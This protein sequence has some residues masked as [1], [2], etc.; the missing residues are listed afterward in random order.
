MVT[1]NPIASI[2]EQ[3]P[4]MILDGGMGTELERRGADLSDPL[5]SARMLIDSPHLI[6]QIHYDYFQAGADVAVTASYQSTL[7]GFVRR[8]IETSKAEELLLSS[9][10]LSCRARERFWAEPSHRRNRV[11]PLVAASIGSYGA[12]LADGSEFSGDY[13]LTL[14]QLMD[15]HR[16]RLKLLASSDA[17]LIAFE[18]IP[19]K[20]EGMAV[21]RLLEEFPR[22]VAWMSFSC[23]SG[24]QVCHGEPF[25][26]C[27]ALAD[28]CEQIVA[29]GLNCTAP[30]FVESLLRS[31]RGTEKPLVAYPNSGEIWDATSHSWISKADTIPFGQ[32]ARLWYTSGARLIGG[33]CRTA[34]E[35][36][37]AISD[38]LRSVNSPDSSRLQPQRGGEIS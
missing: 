24:S 38:A 9:V 21:L 14:N 32:A 26:E 4:V 23:R 35:D 20:L 3:V 15:F 31:A 27:V 18:T 34:P 6:E 29:V 11:S 8:G 28:T 36:I 10:R 12:F 33:C 30:R 37:A 22:T 7:E 2:L 1:H 25:L 19:S 16:P 17:D 13:G 5:W